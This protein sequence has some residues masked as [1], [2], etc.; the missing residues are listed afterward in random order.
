MKAIKH[1]W[2]VPVLGIVLSC[3]K[4]EPKG[5]IVSKDYPVEAFQNVQLSGKYKVFFVS[6]GQNF[7]NVE[8]YQNIADNLKI[9]VKNN[10]LTISEKRETEAIDFYNL[11]IYAKN[12]LQN[13]TVADEVEF[14]VSG[15]I[16]GE[17]VR[18]DLKNNAKFIG[19]IRSKT[20]TVEMKDLSRANFIGETQNATIKI[21]D[22]AN[23]IAPY[24]QI[25]TLDL[26]AKNGNYTEVNVKD[27]LKGNIRNTSKLVFYSEPVKVFKADKTASIK[28]QK[29]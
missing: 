21:A 5:D 27:T 19:S 3:G 25:S 4:I 1:I 2:A 26:E 23:I 14:N 28:Q 22:T 24:W 8:S 12:P 20:A 18:V 15:E 9:E 17:N 7:V 29:L 16:R 11:V 6:S 13:I 10:T